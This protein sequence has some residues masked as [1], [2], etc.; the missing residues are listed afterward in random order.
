M[1]PLKRRDRA[2]WYKSPIPDVLIMRE[3]ATKF[4]GRHDFA[5]FGNRQHHK[6]SM[7][8]S[9]L[10]TCRTIRRIS[11]VEE[12]EE[13]IDFRFDFELDG[14]LYKMVSLPLRVAVPVVK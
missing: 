14:A 13:G 10:E 12:D 3:A 9:A 5:S 2:L 6:E 1:D 7:H 4:E 11:L 8:G